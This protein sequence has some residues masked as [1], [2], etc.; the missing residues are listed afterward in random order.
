MAKCQN[1]IRE[2]SDTLCRQVFNDIIAGIFYFIRALLWK[3]LSVKLHIHT[4][5]QAQR[6]PGAVE[7]VSA[8]ALWCMGCA[9]LCSCWSQLLGM[10]VWEDLGKKGMLLSWDAEIIQHHQKKS[11]S[12]EV[13][14]RR[15]WYRPESVSEKCHVSAHR[16]FQKSGKVKHTSPRT[17]C[18]CFELLLRKLL[19]GLGEL[20]W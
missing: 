19:E 15:N 8:C 13:L 12:I 4:Q 17:P 1:L 3:E 14:L 7:S 6:L 10:E 16:S 2:G 18:H 20:R 5:M 9:G 11:V